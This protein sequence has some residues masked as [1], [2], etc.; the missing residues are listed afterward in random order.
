MVAAEYFLE[1][2]GLTPQDSNPP[3]NSKKIDGV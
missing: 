2:L 1:Q 3:H